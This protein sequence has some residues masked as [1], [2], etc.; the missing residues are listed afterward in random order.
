MELNN[1]PLVSIGVLCYNTG[2]YTIEALECIKRQNYPN[3]ELI[4]IDDCSTDNI[5]VNLIRDWLQKNSDCGFD[6]KVNFRK[7]NEGVHSGLNEILEKSTGKYLN[8]ISDD[9]WTD[10]KMVKQISEL[11]KLGDEYALYYGKMLTIDKDS[12][13]L[14]ETEYQHYF[15]DDNE[16]PKGYIFSYCVNNFS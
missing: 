15:P 4:I 8:F 7:K 10:D 9:L 5:S 14:K 13:L 12:Q 11:E 3:I 1:Y 2:K 6:I 16:L